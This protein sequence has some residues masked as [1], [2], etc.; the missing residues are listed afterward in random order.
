MHLSAL[1]P[2][3]VVADV[4]GRV[5]GICL[6]SEHGGDPV[7]NVAR[8]A[9]EF[10]RRSRSTAN[11]A[12]GSV[13][14]DTP[15][16]VQSRVEADRVSRVLIAHGARGQVAT[17]G[18]VALDALLL[19][20]GDQA[21]ATRHEPS[22][23]VLRIAEYDALHRSTL[24]QTLRHWLDTLGDVSTAAQRAGVHANTFRYRLRRAAQ[25]G[26]IDLDDP[27]QRLAA[28]IQLRLT[29]LRSRHPK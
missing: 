3:A 18:Q 13:G 19:E 25:V 15:G 24:L 11:L 5:Y 6:A 14:R 23:A 22:L 16:L 2:R 12:I 1:Y 29:S 20:L 28:A 27:D 8:A 17:I 26:G 21:G 9:A 4:G 7:K 10:L